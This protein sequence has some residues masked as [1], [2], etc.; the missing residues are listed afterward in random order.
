MLSLQNNPPRFRYK[1]IGGIK[2][3]I[4]NK[5]QNKYTDVLPFLIEDTSTSFIQRMFETLIRIMKTAKIT[6]Q[7]E[8]V[9]NGNLFKLTL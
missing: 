8:N 9:P 1:Y 2:S 3:L 6:L 5:E 4:T 7:Y